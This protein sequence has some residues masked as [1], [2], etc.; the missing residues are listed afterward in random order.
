MI[1]KGYQFFDSNSGKIMRIQGVDYY[2]RPN[3]GTLDSGI[4]VDM[5]TKQYRHIW[6]RDIQE[7]KELGLNAIRIYSV[8]PG[9]DHTDFMCALNNVGIYVVVGLASYC[10]TCAI[11]RDEAPDCYPMELK[12]R[13]QDIINEF[14]KYSN[15]LGFSAGNEVNHFVPPGKH[16]Q[17]NAPCL[18]KFISD[19]RA[20]VVNCNTDVSMRK[21]PIG[22]VTA[23][24]DRDVNALYYNCLSDP[25]ET[26]ENAEW[27]G[28]NAYLYC[29]GNVTEL[30]ESEGFRKLKESFKS[31]NYSIPVLLTEFGCL[32]KTFPTINGFEAQRPF[33]QAKWLGTESALRDLFAGGFAFEYSIEKSVGN[34]AYPFKVFGEQNYGIGYFS[35]ENCDDQTIP[36]KYVPLPSFDKLK[37]AFQEA[38]DG[39]DNKLTLEN[40]TF[41]PHRMQRSD[42]P[43]NFP[44]L[45]SFSW[46]SDLVHNRR[47]PKRSDSEFTCANR[48]NHKVLMKFVIIGNVMI[49]LLT[50]TK[51]FE[52]W[53]DGKK[54]DHLDSMI[55]AKNSLR[56]AFESDNLIPDKK[57]ESQT[58]LNTVTDSLNSN[59][60]V[61]NTFAL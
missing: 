29:N 55:F 21:V 38:R 12:L 10:P 61:G 48:H 23:D 25:L 37:N 46:K 60:H 54:T 18:K 52:R 1:I 31:Y 20:Y 44:N 39:Y 17:W 3:A 56:I 8:D 30:N 47:C 2:P 6:E 41:D 26:L 24:S 19:M 5:Y 57:M 50:I 58:E 40:Y 51:I 43:E 11:T 13:G 15:T 7:F 16:P 45:K 59:K 14:S 27:F 4:S 35:P 28:I 49:L 33:L 22:L 32:S 53:N 34:T 9:K 42:C 36:C